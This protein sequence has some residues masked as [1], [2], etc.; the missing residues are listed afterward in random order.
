MNFIEKAKQLYN[1]K[2]DYSKVVYK[3]C[4][5]K[6]CIICPHHGEFFQRPN[7]HLKGHGCKQCG[8]LKRSADRRMSVDDFIDASN[9]THNN[10]YDYSKVVYKNCETKVCIIC[11]HHGEFKQRPYN[12]KKGE[13]CPFCSKT[14]KTQRMTDM[15]KDNI[16]SK[17]EFI[18]KAKIIHGSAYDY[19]LVNYIGMHYKVCII[20]P[21]HGEFWQLP[22]NHLQPNQCPKCTNSG[23][24][25]KEIEVLDF[26]RSNS[27]YDVYSNDRSIIGLELDIYVPQIQAAF[28]FNGLYW[29]SEIFKEN[30]YHIQKTKMC[31]EKGIHLIHIYEDDWNNRQEIVKSRILSLMGQ[32]KRIYARQCD[33]R[34]LD[35][36]TTKDFLN[37][38]HIQGNV[39]GKVNLGLFYKDEV[40]AVMTFGNLRTNLGN[41]HIEDIWELLRFC[42][43]INTSVVGGA[44]KLFK[45]FRKHYNPITVM[46]YA[47]RSWTMNNGNTVYD[48]LGFTF[49]STTRPNYFYVVNGVRK[50]RFNFRKDILVKQGFNKMESERSI[51]RSRKI[52]R[53]YNSGNLKYVWNK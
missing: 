27:S 12:H 40:M 49:H 9:K 23:V 41:H 38:N 53:I 7:D 34:I 3:N 51:M 4:G 1:N 21:I 20:C 30:N 2:Y 24:S 13:G 50:N 18:Q 17:E 5:T 26:I 22:H 15:N 42:N 47:D 14:K 52:Y 36:K 46:S 25:N 35:S 45:Y 31:E 6:V 19:S 10:K 39:Y 43:K 44:S 33:C 11:P 37:I 28:E 29:H 8:I 48:H 16:L 32:N